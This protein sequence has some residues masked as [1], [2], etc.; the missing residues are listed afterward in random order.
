MYEYGTS[1]R[2]ICLCLRK[3]AKFT[4]ITYCSTSRSFTRLL[5]RQL[6]NGAHWCRLPSRRRNCFVFQHGCF[7]LFHS[8][9][10]AR[11]HSCGFAPILASL[12]DE[13]GRFFLRCTSCLSALW[14]VSPFLWKILSQCWLFHLWAG[15]YRQDSSS[16]GSNAEVFPHSPFFCS[17]CPPV[18]STHSHTLSEGRDPRTAKSVA[19]HRTSGSQHLWFWSSTTRTASLPLNFVT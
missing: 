6:Q 2:D 10:T 5:H 19:L 18:S 4:S 15:Q 17:V 1:I 7:R 8:Q 16:Y 12:L 3:V 14:T 13:F 11:W 9:W